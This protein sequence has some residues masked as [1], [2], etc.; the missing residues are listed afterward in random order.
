[1]E[2][3]FL[4]YRRRISEELAAA[5]RAITGT[6]RLRHFQLIEAY[7]S[8]LERIGEGLPI[9]RGEIERLKADCTASPVA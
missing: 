5:N 7:L 4:F 8:H 6:G 3:D 1:M 9:S 2:P